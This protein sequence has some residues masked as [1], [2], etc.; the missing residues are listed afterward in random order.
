MFFYQNLEG[1]RQVEVRIRFSSNLGEGCKELLEIHSASSLGASLLG[2]CESGEDE[3]SINL[4]HS[5]QLR[6][7]IVIFVFVLVAVVFALRRLDDIRVFQDLH[8][9]RTLELSCVQ[10]LAK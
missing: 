2:A 3:V 6:S 7:S 4:S 9:L 1:L 10:G 5:C 8:E